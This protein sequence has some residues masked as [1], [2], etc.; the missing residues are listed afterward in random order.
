MRRYQIVDAEGQPVAEPFTSVREAY[1]AKRIYQD[2]CSD[3]TLP[4]RVVPVDDP[5]GDAI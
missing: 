4:L 5:E 3:V 2:H 1:E